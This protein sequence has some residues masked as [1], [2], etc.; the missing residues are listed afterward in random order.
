MNRPMRARSS[1]AASV[2]SSPRKWISPS[3]TSRF[4]WPMT[5]LARRGLAGAVGAHQGVDLALRDGQVDPLEDLLVPGA[6]VQVLDLEHV[7]FAWFAGA[8]AG[9]GDG[10]RVGEKSTRSASVV[11]CRART[12]PPWTRVHSSFVAQ[13]GRHRARGSTPRGAS[14]VGGEAGHRRDRALERLD[15]LVHRDLL[16]GAGQP[17]APVRAARAATR[18]ARLSR[19]TT[20]SR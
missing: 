2:M 7:L 8:G 15:D 17:V 11:S 4:G 14:A 18:S 3:V 10:V 9:I 13:R 12:M 6:D 5:T 16:G 19:A 20:C 1:G